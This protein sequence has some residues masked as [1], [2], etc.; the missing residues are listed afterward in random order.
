MINYE[1]SG[2]FNGR[3]VSK[4]LLIQFDDTTISND[5]IYQEGFELTE[6][7][8]SQNEL[9]FGSCEASVVK[10]KIRNEFGSLKG[11]WLN[12]SMVLD[13]KTDKPFQI[14][15]YKVDTC[16]L[17]GDKKYL[18][19]TAYDSMYDIINTD[20]VEWY[21]GLTFPLTLKAFRDSFFLHMG[22]EQEET[23]LIQDGVLLEKTIDADEITGL[24]V[25]S[26]ICELNGVFGHINR[27]GV[28]VYVSLLGGED[29][30][31]PSYEIFPSDSLYPI[32]RSGYEIGT[33]RYQTCQYEEYVTQSISKVQI[34]QEENDIGAVVGDGTNLYAVEDNFLVYGK[35]PAVLSEICERLYNKITGVYYRPFNA[36]LPGNPCIEV[37][38]D[39]VIHTKTMDVQSYLLE[40]TINGIQSL[41]DT[42][43]ANGVY[44]YSTK[45]N[46]VQKE[47]R[48]LKG[49]SNVLERNVEETRETIND[50]EK[51]LQ[52]E[53]TKN[54]EGIKS[55][56]SKGEVSSEIS[57]ESG[58]ISLKGNRIK[59][60]SDNFIVNEDGTITATNANI[61]GAITASR[62][63]A[64]GKIVYTP[65]M[66]T[67]EDVQSVKNILLG[68]Q[69]CTLADIERYD[70][71]GDGVLTNA[72]LVRINNLISGR[73]DS[74]EVDTSIKI[75]PMNK[76][77]VVELYG[78][79]IKPNGIYAKTGTVDNVYLKTIYVKRENVGWDIGQTGRIS[80]A[81]YSIDFVQG[82]ATYIMEN[83]V[84]HS[85]DNGEYWNYPDGTL[86]C[87]K[88]ESIS[89]TCDNT[90]GSLYES[91]IIDLGNWPYAFIDTPT[92]SQPTFCGNYFAFSEG[93]QDV[94]ATSAGKTYLCRPTNT[95]ELITGTLHVIGIG[96]W[97]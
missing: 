97:K 47:I 26:A 43:D 29:W 89:I 72:D 93:L 61:S 18:D 32:D 55:K 40:R 1:Y 59:I 75:D 76:S 83:T 17:S 69:E 2:L 91:S 41:K 56:V 8:C 77:N 25:I 66:F 3:S 57:Q 16:E 85:D 10:I 96:R 28:F 71:N 53:I 35:T 4:K 6:S 90:F 22:I 15:K 50:V 88:K 78:V 95:E 87:A 36:V 86:I 34:R 82:V 31:C 27:Q 58:L 38:D 73:A 46:S 5:R 65:D 12:I 84:Y 81:G 9:R 64:S 94:S 63:E 45:G 48:Q 67:E 80:V 79:A 44:E 14:G 30:L 54:A 23:E 37:G 49:K 51:N 33:S 74:Y 21:D 68:K 60:Q 52:T 19:I 42:F 70:I 20:V 11:K 92:V 62:Y 24:K 7:L 39:L 13:G